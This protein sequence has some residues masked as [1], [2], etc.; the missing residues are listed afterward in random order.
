MAFL[1]WVIGGVFSKGTIIFTKE[2][3]GV[4]TYAAVDNQPCRA[5]NTG[6]GPR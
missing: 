5:R 3:A 4:E 1:V 2:W 6:L